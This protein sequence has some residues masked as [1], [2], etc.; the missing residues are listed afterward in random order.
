MSGGQRSC[1]HC[2]Y[3]HPLDETLPPGTHVLIGECRR[4]APTKGWPQSM[5]DEWCGEFEPSQLPVNRD[6]DTGPL[7][8]DC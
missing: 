6:P 2:V 5:W 7:G 1:E 8:S 4:Y 3:W